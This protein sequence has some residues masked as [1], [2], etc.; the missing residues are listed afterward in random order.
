MSHAL[1]TNEVMD[2]LRRRIAERALLSGERLPS[3]RRFAAQ[4]GVSPS[5]VVVA[6]DRLLA[7]GVI[8]SRPGSG[9]YVTG[10]TV[11][12]DLDAPATDLDRSV[13]PLWV[14]RQS[15]DA[16]AEVLKPGC[17]W[18]PADWMP[19]T[20]I[21][22]ALRE[23]SRGED[24]LLADYGTSRGGQE[25]RQSLARQSAEEGLPLSPDCVL[26]TSSATQTIDLICRL[27]LRP[28]DTVLVDDPCYFNFRALLRV[29]NVR[30]VS[31][32]FTRSGPDL[33]AFAAAL[34]THSPRLYLTNSA[35]HNPTGATLSAQ[36]AHRLLVLAA[37]RNLTIVEDDTFASLEP[38]LSPRLAILDGLQRVIRIGSFSKTLSAAARC[39]YIMAR[40]ELIEALT[41]LQ[42]ATSFGGPSPVAAEIV[43]ITLADG[44]YRKHIAATKARL[45]R[46]RRDVGAKLAALGIE[47][48]IMPRGGLYLWCELPDGLATNDLAKRALGRQVV[49]APGNVFSVTGTAEGFVRFNVSQ[50]APKVYDILGDVLGRAVWER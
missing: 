44:S 8:R 9:F 11:L 28:G 48:W 4:L 33:A 22:R 10:Q 43:R 37:E 12:K 45:T 25:L 6:Y 26:L 23:I 20:A 3:I 46:A 30:V 18:M 29:L 34:E 36:T 14:S 7:E 24:S 35:L 15:L 17:G 38:D 40:P 32:P 13:D 42:V 31:V 16:K 47:P 39:G 5:T 2:T 49:L 50:M 1:R 27:L 19:Q 41:D 21:R